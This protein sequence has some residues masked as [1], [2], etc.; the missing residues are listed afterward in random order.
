MAIIKLDSR[1]CNMK[2]LRKTAMPNFKSVTAKHCYLQTTVKLK[3]FYN[4]SPFKQKQDFR[5][6][7]TD[8]SFYENQLYNDLRSG[9]WF[10]ETGL[11]G[12]DKK[13]A[14][15]FVLLYCERFAS[16]YQ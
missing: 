1:T 8:H 3:L 16:W 5:C 15:I 12:Q 6:N 11:F 7:D 4:T 2:L 10:Y 13:N 9:V 14:T